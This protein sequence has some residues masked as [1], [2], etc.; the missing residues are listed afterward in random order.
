MKTNSKRVTTF[1]G[2]TIVGAWLAAVG[3]AAPSYVNYQ[4]LLN[5]A[6]GQPLPTSNYAMEFNIYD[7]AQLGTRVWGPF[8]FD[9]AVAIGHG[10]LVPVVN[11][12]FN[13]VIGPQDT[14]GVAIG[15]AFAGTNRFMEISVAGGP[16]ILPRQQFLS[17]AYAFE[18][19][20]AQ[21]A[22]LAQQAVVASNLVQA[23]ADSLCPPGTIVAFGGTEVPDGWLLCDGR[24]LT[25]AMFPRLYTAISTNWGNGT[26]DSNGNLENPE[27][28]DTGFNL[29]DLRGM[30]LRG[31]N[32]SRTSPAVMDPGVATRTSW[33]MG[34]TG[35][36]VGSIQIDEFLSHNHASGQYKYL[37]RISGAN[38]IISADNSPTELDVK[39]GQEI[40]PAGGNETRPKNAY[41]N[42]IIKY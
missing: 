42:Y 1:V 21:Y 22:L 29:P 38:T 25:N 8:I 40:L 12:R 30:F 33:T 15:T 23:V 34:N 5:G 16:P 17:T 24:S 36:A 18:A 13:V 2:I 4:G 20:N 3:W 26:V 32:G 37:A 14:N 39:S 31:V 19:I 11:G 28:P 27:N 41:V 7:Q 9:G 35:N 10:A 6:D